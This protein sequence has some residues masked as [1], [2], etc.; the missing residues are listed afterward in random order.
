MDCSGL[1]HDALQPRCEQVTVS[2]ACRRYASPLLDLDV[3]PRIVMQILRHGQVDR[4]QGGG[5]V[6]IG[7]PLTG[8]TKTVSGVVLV[9]TAGSWPPPVT[10]K[11][12]GCGMWPAANP[13][14]ATLRWSG[15]WR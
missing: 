10:T 14:P 11:P 3:H 8:H 4:G 2:D 9:L 13:S 15:G 12:F 6:G 1:R 5:R 7:Q